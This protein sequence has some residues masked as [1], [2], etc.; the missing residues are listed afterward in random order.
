MRTLAKSSDH[1]GKAMKEL[2]QT[3]GSAGIPIVAGTGWIGTRRDS[4]ASVPKDSDR[5]LARIE[6][7]D[8][9]RLAALAADAEGELFRRKPQGSGRY[10]RPP[11]G[12]GPVP[13]RCPALRERKERRQG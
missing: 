11:P 1:P 12:P 6:I 13:G 4:M 10:T 7:A 5:S 9:F 3:P 8:L 2:D